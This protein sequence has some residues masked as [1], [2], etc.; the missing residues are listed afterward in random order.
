MYKVQ[1]D[2]IHIITVV[3][4]KLNNQLQLSQEFKVKTYLCRF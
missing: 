1:N 3:L 2:V 4:L